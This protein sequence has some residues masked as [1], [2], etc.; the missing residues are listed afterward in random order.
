VRALRDLA[1]SIA[2]PSELTGLY[3][4]DD[5]GEEESGAEKEV[6]KTVTFISKLLICW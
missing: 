3:S 4:E 2:N 1:K 6:S 5:D